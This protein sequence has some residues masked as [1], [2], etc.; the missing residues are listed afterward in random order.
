MSLDKSQIIQKLSDRGANKPCHRCGHKQFSLID[1]YSVFTLQDNVAGALML[2][3]ANIPIVLAACNNCGAITAH[4]LGALG[5][6]ETNK[7]ESNGNK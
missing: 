1:K 2:G 4:A 6:L 3:G 5:L 7:E